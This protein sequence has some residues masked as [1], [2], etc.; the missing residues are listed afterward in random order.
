ME[1]SQ[2]F[3][4]LKFGPYNFRLREIGLAAENFLLIT[5]RTLMEKLAIRGNEN[6]SNLQNFRVFGNLSYLSYRRNR[7]ILKV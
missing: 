5:V 7:K 6:E 1:N 3:G 2:L 4:L